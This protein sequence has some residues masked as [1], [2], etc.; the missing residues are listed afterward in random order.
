MSQGEPQSL[1][2]CTLTLIMPSILPAAI[3]R[4]TPLKMEARLQTRKP[5]KD[6]WF[7]PLE[8]SSQL[9]IAGA[10]AVTAPLKQLISV[11]SVAPV[12]AI[13]SL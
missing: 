5:A 4:T 8:A 9:L 1:M 3:G 2:K 11:V 6:F 13:S 7:V 12:S 10:A